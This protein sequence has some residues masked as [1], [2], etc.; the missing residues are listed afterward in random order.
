MR[1]VLVLVL[2]LV[3]AMA[4]VASSKKAPSSCDEMTKHVRSC[5]TRAIPKLVERAPREEAAIW[6]WYNAEAR[7]R[8]ALPPARIERDPRGIVDLDH[9]GPD[10]EHI[11][12]DSP[13]VEVY[14]T[15]LAVGVIADR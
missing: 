14:S 8:V 12:R 11:Y 7:V 4:I 6:Y 3:M 9:D 10:A 15:T 2:V 5:T 13:R 1:I